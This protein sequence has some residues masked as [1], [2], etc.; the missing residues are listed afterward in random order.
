VR[1]P[2]PPSGW[3][4]ASSFYRP[5]SGSLQTCHTVLATCGGMVYSA[6]E[7]MVVLANL[8]LSG[9]VVGP[10]PAQER[11]RGWLCGN[12]SFG[13]R[14]YA[15]SRVRLTEGHK[16]HSSGRGGVLSSGLPQRRGWCCSARDGSTGPKVTEETCSTGLMSRSRPARARGK[17]SYLFRGFRHPLS[18]VRHAGCTR[19][20]GAVSRS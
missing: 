7:W 2:S 10:V 1:Y 11:L 3:G 14:P 17:H 13:C 8:A 16:V 6:T 20:G 15:D 12:F 4:T 5:R 18:R 9:V 19:V